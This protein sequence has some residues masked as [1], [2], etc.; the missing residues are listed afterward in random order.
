[1][2]LWCQRMLPNTLHIIAHALRLIADGKSLD[3]FSAGAIPGF[4]AIL[5]K[6]YSPDQY[7]LK[8]I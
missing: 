7:L 6:R 4:S 2:F 1:M 3:E 8:P 5:A